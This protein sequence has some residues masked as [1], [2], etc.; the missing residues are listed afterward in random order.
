MF[1]FLN[2]HALLQSGKNEFD[3]EPSPESFQQGASHSKIRQTQMIYCVSCYKYW[4]GLELCM[5]GISP[6]QPPWRRDWVD[7]PKLK[8]RY[9]DEVDLSDL[10]VE[11]Q[12]Y[13]AVVTRFKVVPQHWMCCSG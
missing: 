8:N 10:P 1:S 11:I 3:T 7:M 4:G 13:K 12:R 6:P 5:G 2:T 9:A